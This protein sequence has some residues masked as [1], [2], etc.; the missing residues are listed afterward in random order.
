MKWLSFDVELVEDI[1]DFG[2]VLDIGYS[3]LTSR[4]AWRTVYSVIVVT[5]R[6][7]TNSIDESMYHTRN[8]TRNR[9]QARISLAFLSTSVQTRWNSHRASRFPVVDEIGTLEAKLA[10]IRMRIT[11]GYAFGKSRPIYRLS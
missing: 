10:N 11:K 6:C 3:C 2:C 4:M 1:Q 9:N 7:V 8:F 5:G